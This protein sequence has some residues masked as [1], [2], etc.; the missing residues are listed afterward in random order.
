MISAVDRKGN[1][2]L[3][4]YMYKLKHNLFYP[5]TNTRLDSFENPV[6]VDNKMILKALLL[7]L[8]KKT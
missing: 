7:K 3:K 5:S 8:K 2:E 4:K 6:V 1:P